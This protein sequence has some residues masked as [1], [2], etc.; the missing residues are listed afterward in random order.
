MRRWLVRSILLC[1][2]VVTLFTG[3]SLAWLF[4]YSGDLPEI[5]GL[6]RYAPNQEGRASDPCLGES[7]VVPYEAIG[8]NFRAALTSAEVND[9]PGQVTLR[10]QISRT[11]FCAPSK[12]F[13]RELKEWR[14][15]EQLRW[16]FSRN[17]LLT[18]YSN[19]A[20]FG[21]NLIGIEAASEYFFKKEPNQLDLAEAALL[22]GLLKAPSH[23][24]P[25]RYPDRALE[26]R[27][28]V[29]DTMV[30]DHAISAQEGAVAKAV[31]L[32]VAIKP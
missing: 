7:A 22:A 32:P 10:M 4:L 28:K 13:A 26:R 31:G 1:A 5:G 29:I 17:D 19:R 18:I 25:Y 6:R 27:N 30:E 8:D 14:V 21:Q 15:A 24:S 2:A 16:R 20:S 9:R 12:L 3:V 23:Y 11:L